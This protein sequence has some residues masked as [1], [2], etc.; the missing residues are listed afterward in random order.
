VPNAEN[1]WL[2]FNRSLVFIIDPVRN[3][4][5]ARFVARPARDGAQAG[6]FR[7]TGDV[8]RD[9]RVDDPPLAG[10]SE[11]F[12]GRPQ[13]YRP[14]ESYGGIRGPKDRFASCKSSRVSG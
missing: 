6:S 7:S 4:L 1:P 9:R 3:R 13:I 8:N 2:D 14:A 10:K 12:A 11:S 5:T